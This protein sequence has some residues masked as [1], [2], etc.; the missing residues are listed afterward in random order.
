[1]PSSMT[2]LANRRMV[3]RTAARAGAIAR[4]NVHAAAE[5]DGEVDRHDEMSAGFIGNLHGFFPSAGRMNPGMEKKLTHRDLVGN[6]DEAAPGQ[7][8][9]SQRAMTQFEG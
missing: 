7:M 5:R 6:L 4:R 3:R 9:R 2:E 8:C 1:L